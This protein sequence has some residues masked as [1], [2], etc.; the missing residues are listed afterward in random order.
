MDTNHKY[1]LNK[2]TDSI[3]KIEKSLNVKKKQSEGKQSKTKNNR[4]RRHELV[5]PEE[6]PEEDE[7]NE[8]I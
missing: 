4:K 5:F 3:V 7:E 1:Q 6:V 8:D 2:T